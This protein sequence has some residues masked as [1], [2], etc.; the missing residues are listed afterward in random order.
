MS[1]ALPDGACDTHCHVFGPESLFP[2]DPKRISTP[3]EAPKEAL[4]AMH[5]RYGLDR[6]VIVQP[7]LHGVDNRVTLDAIAASGNAYRGVALVPADVTGEMLQDL[8]AG[9]IRGVRFNFLKHL[10]LP[11]SEDAIRHIAE[12]IA[13]L[14]W[15]ILLHITPEHLE[16]AWNYV[17]R[18]DVPFVIDHMARISTADGLDQPAFKL[19]LDIVADPR[20]WVKISGGD[21]ASAAGAPFDDAI[22]FARALLEASPERTLWGTDWPHP[23]VKGPMPQETDL[24]ALL[25]KI[26][27]EKDRLQQVLVDNPDRLYRF[28]APLAAG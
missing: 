26:V 9:G 4:F 14:G 22:P 27:P 3:A 24:V 1:G 15:H 6:A 18:L 19:L 10:G 23:N 12:R 11:P 2:Y 16:T 7:N 17:R 13:P 25:H 28:H 21:R 8:D 5:R 20:C